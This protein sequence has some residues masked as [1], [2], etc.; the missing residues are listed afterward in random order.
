MRRH[1]NF[2]FYHALACCV[3]RSKIILKLKIKEADKKWNFWLVWIIK[4]MPSNR[5][6]SWSILSTSTTY[7][8]S[9]SA[10]HFTLNS[11]FNQHI[12]YLCIIFKATS[13]WICCTSKYE[14][15]VNGIIKI[16][17]WVIDKFYCGQRLVSDITLK[18]SLIYYRIF[19]YGS[20]ILRFTTSSSQLQ[21]EAYV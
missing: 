18:K 15:F 16:R 8:L 14:I 9:L 20:E 6:S 1:E 12:L 5:L 11:S 7:N 2:I 13:H 3:N 17:L 19:N 10:S 21:E 4:F